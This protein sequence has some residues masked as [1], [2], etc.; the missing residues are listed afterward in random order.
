MAEKAAG[1][2]VRAKLREFTA[3]DPLGRAP[4]EDPWSE[5]RRIEVIDLRLDFRFRH[6]LGKASRFF[7]E[8]ERRR[9]LASRCPRCGTVWM[10]PRA[11]CGNELAVTQWVELTGRGILAAATECAYT[12]TSGG[13]GARLVLGYVALDGAS[14]LLLHQIRNY[15]DAG[16]LHA[17]LPVRVVWAEGSVDHPMEL[18]W[19]EPAD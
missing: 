17:G 19:F 8:L 10:P 3:A 15:G 13:G 18:F 11:A 5:F 2:A 14:T 7:L 4:G 1:A 6:S 9:L 12:L 16:R